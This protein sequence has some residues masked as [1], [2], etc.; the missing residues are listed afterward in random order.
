M[1]RGFCWPWLSRPGGRS[2][3]ASGFL[4]GLVVAAWGPLLRCFGV[5]VGLGCRGLGAAPTWLR[6][7]CWA[8]LSRPGARS[9]GAWSDCRSA[10][11]G[12]TCA[13]HKVVAAWG[14]LLRCAGV[15][16]GFQ[17]GADAVFGVAVAGRESQGLTHPGRVDDSGFGQKRHPHRVKARLGFGARY[18]RRGR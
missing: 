17:G 4:L 16:F 12:A 11:H 10:A 6:G 18:F 13:I 14:P 5:S 15:F 8:W 1:L 3:E 7:F 9:C 2:Y